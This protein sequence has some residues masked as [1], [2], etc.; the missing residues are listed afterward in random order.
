MRTRV[1]V[2]VFSVYFGALFT[3]I[4]A[5][6]WL[7]VRV[8]DGEQGDMGGL[9]EKRAHIVRGDN[10]ESG[11]VV[12]FPLRRPHVVESLESHWR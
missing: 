4:I 5:A 7:C 6:A 10:G 2:R 3:A 11:P 1:F 8:C 12:N 9:Q